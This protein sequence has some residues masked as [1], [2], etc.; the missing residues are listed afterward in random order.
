[1]PL[2]VRKSEIIKIIKST[3]I[4]KKRANLLKTILNL[5][6]LV[7]VLATSMPVINNGK[8]VVKIFCIYYPV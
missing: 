2:K 8:E 4:I 1:M 7:S 6:K 3:I 5:Q